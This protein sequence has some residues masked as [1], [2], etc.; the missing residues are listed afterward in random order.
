MLDP[1]AKGVGSV[2]TK[3][4]PTPFG[5]SA[6]LR[7]TDSMNHKLMLALRHKVL[8]I[9]CLI[10][11]AA[12]H[13]QEITPKHLELAVDFVH[14]LSSADTEYRHKN[15]FVHWKG[16]NGAEKNEARTDCSGFL[17]AL[18]GQTY[19]LTRDDFQK[20]S[21]KARPLA[22]T[23]YDLIHEG[24]GFANI[25]AVQDIRPGDIIAVKFPPGEDDTGHA[26]LISGVPHKRAESAPIEDGT[27]QWEVKVIDASKTGHGI[28]DTRHKPDG[29]FSC[30][31]GEGILRLYTG[32]DG[33]IVGYAWSVQ[34]KSAFHGQKSKQLVVG[35][36]DPK[37]KP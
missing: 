23:Y 5:K 3:R 28:T 7:R 21:G 32:K 1:E 29:S 11:P 16:V 27:V 15:T 20:W 26:M 12:S 18:L 14:N 24:K 33:H 31:V 4:L 19:G 13:A 37:F 10:T 2:F 36:F 17:D 9:V 6:N 35:R 22:R 25:Q 30:G 8:L 34:A